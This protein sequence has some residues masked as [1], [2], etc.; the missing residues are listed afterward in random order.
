MLPL[1]PEICKR[2]VQ[3]AYYWSD[4][5]ALCSTCKAFQ[6]EAEVK[7]YQQLQFADHRRALLAC[8]AVIEN[9]R[10]ALHVKCF[11]FNQPNDRQR[12]LDLGREFWTAIQKAL[13]AM[14][15]L[16]ILFLC[17]RSFSN[18]WVLDNPAIQF[19]LKEAKLWSVWNAPLTRFL[20]RQ[21]SLQTLHFVDALEDITHQII[22][23]ALPDLRIFDGPFMI[24]HQLHSSPLV[25][26]QVMI[27]TD[28]HQ[29]SLQ[30]LGCF[31]KTLKS[32]NLLDIPEE[33]AC[34]FLSVV[35]ATLPDLK[36]IGILPYPVVSVSPLYQYRSMHALTTIFFPETRFLPISHANALPQKH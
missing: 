25:C 33:W 7:L 36:H 34:R 32:L 12:H 5:L 15:N 3:N 10:L 1:S 18:S 24:A 9:E 17:D 20:E 35:S 23:T 31:R 28:P 16:E 21:S 29:I 8:N 6:R 2:V 30:L 4:V 22:P 14:S 26:L 19:K 27:D 11:W 13:I